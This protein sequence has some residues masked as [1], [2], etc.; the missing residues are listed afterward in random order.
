MID[1]SAEPMKIQFPVTKTFIQYP[2]LRNPSL[3]AFFQERDTLSCPA[4]RMASIDE[5]EEEPCSLKAT[6]DNS[7]A[8]K[9]S[10]EIEYTVKNTFVD[11]GESLRNPS[12]EGFFHERE[13]KSCPAT[14]VQSLD[15][16]QVQSPDDAKEYDEQEFQ[17]RDS[18]ERVWD[19]ERPAL[20]SLSLE[21]CLRDI[22]AKYQDLEPFDDIS[23]KTN[24]PQ[25][26]APVTPEIVSD[27]EDDIKEGIKPFNISIADG[28]GLW[29]VGSEKHFLGTCKPCAFLWKDENGC[30]NG[31]S[32]TFC[33]MCPPG[34]KKRRKKDKLV[35]RKAVRQFHRQQ[36]FEQY[37]RHNQGFQDAGQHQVFHRRQGFPDA[38]QY[39]VRSHGTYSIN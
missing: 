18:H 36:A 39:N 10:K 31:A 6:L 16:T 38:G 35:M 19:M 17:T 3:E 27:P 2:A 24:T 11:F 26:T 30:G 8:F 5:D 4:S 34:E 33:H 22:E 25:I 32:C 28:L 23:T 1:C 29:S 14:R 37:Q 15:D 21:E 7:C 20:R 12:L 13:L 9:F